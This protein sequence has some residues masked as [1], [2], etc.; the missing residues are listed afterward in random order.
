M[1]IY[2]FLLTL[3]NKIFIDLF[4]TKFIY[5]IKKKKKEKHQVH[6]HFLSKHRLKRFLKL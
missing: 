2:T 4:V 1:C 6:N 3:K 5:L